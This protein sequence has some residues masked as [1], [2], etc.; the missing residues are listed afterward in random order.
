MPAVYPMRAQSVLNQA[1]GDEARVTGQ[2]AA[3]EKL[4]SKK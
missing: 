2:L 3:K 4:A 1:A